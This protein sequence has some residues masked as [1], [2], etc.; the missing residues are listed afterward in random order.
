VIESLLKK[1]V[2][3]LV[4]QVSKSFKPTWCPRLKIFVEFIVTDFTESNTEKLKM[5][6][7]LVAECQGSMEQLKKV[8]LQGPCVNSFH[9]GRSC[10]FAQIELTTDVA[11]FQ[12]AFK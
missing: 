8:R 12:L 6:E 9:W 10:S 3:T 1:Y 5:L 7:P 11:D 2:R 4:T